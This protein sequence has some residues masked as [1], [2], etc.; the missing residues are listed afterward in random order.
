MTNKKQIMQRITDSIEQC[1]K[2]D[3]MAKYF[4][5]AKEDL[6]RLEDQGTEAQLLL[7]W[8]KI[9]DSA[10]MA[11][12][13]KIS[14]F[15][16]YVPELWPI[17]VAWYPEFPLK[18]LISVQGMDQAIAYMAFSQLKT[19][20]SKGEIQVGEV[21]ETATGLRTINGSY[22]T[23][24]VQG[25]QLKAADF[26]YDNTDK[27]DTAALVYFPLTVASGYLDKYAVTITSTDANLNGKWTPNN[28]NNGVIYFKNAAGTDTTSVTMD[29]Q[30]GALVI[31]EQSTA[32]ATT[33][34]AAVVYYVWDIQYATEDTLPQ[35]VE[36]VIL[37]SM[38]ARPR[39]LGL[40]WSVF[41]EYVK[42]TQFGTDIRED[43]TRRVLAILFQYQTRYIL[44][45]MYNF[46][47]QPEATITIPTSNITVESKSQEVIKLLNNEAKKIAQATGRMFG[48]KLVVG[49]DMR[50][51]LESLPD[52]YFKKANYDDKG[53]ESPR[54]LG[55]YGPYQV[56]Y[57]P[58]RPTDTGFMTYRGSEWSDAAYY[59]GE[60]M[61]IVPSDAIQLGTNVRSAFCS[62][63][64]HKY[65]KP[66]AV[67]PLKFVIQ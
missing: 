2:N 54:E 4:N 46:S 67:V 21:V 12:F 33:V 50:S 48:N 62:M 30:T 13:M 51:W 49:M 42:K 1:S 7:N 38:E 8:K 47:T 63:E 43:T 58:N 60:Y 28:V 40:K 6:P 45:T 26:Q 18:D 59:L 36:D 55:T 32:S 37:E 64:A 17:V 16:P 15:G 9:E 56:F 19:A 41:S 53:Y 31:H 22:P 20:T 66:M 5:L 10:P 52:T 23:G 35:L 11:D 57:D 14:N 3:K 29:M 44:D 24:E 39:A 25:E 34:S 65:H 61:P 27:T